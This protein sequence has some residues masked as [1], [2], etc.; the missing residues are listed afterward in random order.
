[1]TPAVAADLIRQALLA[2]FWLCLPLLAA[3]F[4]AGILLSFLQTLTAI[5]DPAFSAVPRLIVFLA[6]LLL[7]TPW[8]LSKWVAYTTSLL[9]NL[10]RHAH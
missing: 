2:A 7:L 3:G 6:A 8:M 4:L 10:A 1:M 5:Q 9:S